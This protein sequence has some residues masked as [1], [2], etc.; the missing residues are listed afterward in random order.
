MA[1]QFADAFGLVVTLD[2][3]A[4]AGDGPRL[5]RSPRTETSRSGEELA[6]AQ[7]PT[8]SSPAKGA[9]FAWRRRE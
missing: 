9:G 6:N 3:W 7:S 1:D 2:A 5:D 8:A 4:G